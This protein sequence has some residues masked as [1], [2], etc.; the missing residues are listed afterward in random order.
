MRRAPAALAVAL[1]CL[2]ACD[3]YWSV[4]VAVRD[5]A[6][7]PVP[8][9]SVILVCPERPA[10]SRVERTGPDGT[11]A[12]G[13]MGNALPPRCTVGVARRGYATRRT[14]FEALCGERPLG[15]CERVRQDRVVL[16]PIDA[17]APAR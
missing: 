13:G 12:L 3:P 7:R 1:L 5:P 2:G 11:A 16:D 9:A 4:S 10:E 15:E 17:P 6:D 8:D 14:S